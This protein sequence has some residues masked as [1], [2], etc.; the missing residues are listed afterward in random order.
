MY[1]GSAVAT[2]GS[3]EGGCRHR[4]AQA[5]IDRGEGCSS[6]HRGAQRRAGASPA[7]LQQNPKPFPSNPRRRRGKDPLRE[8]ERELHKYCLHLR[9]EAWLYSAPLGFNWKS[10]PSAPTPASS[11]FN[12]FSQ[13]SCCSRKTLRQKSALPGFLNPS[14]RV[15][16]AGARVAWDL[17][18]VQGKRVEED[19]ERET[20]L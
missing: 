1:Q 10:F 20:W 18:S 4:A 7:V 6:L 17:V 2:D 12:K 15:I 9:G 11:G 14:R 19:G 5:R 8:A 16:T 3:G 13:H